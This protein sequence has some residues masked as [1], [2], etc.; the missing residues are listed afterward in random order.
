[1]DCHEKPAALG[2]EPF[3]AL[4]GNPNSGKSVVFHQLTGIYTTVSNYPGTTLQILE[5]RV[6]KKR[7]I[8][9][10]GVYSISSATTEERITLDVARHASC[11]VNIVNAL[12]LD[13]ELFLTLQLIDMGVPL[14]IVLNVTDEA[15]KR[16][17]KID[18]PLLEKR[19]GT[20]IYETVAVTG[21]GIKP[22]ID[23]IKG[24]KLGK[25]AGKQPKKCS[26]I[27][28]I[29]DQFDRVLAREG[30][31]E[32]LQKYGLK[33]G[34]MPDE[35]YQER[36]RRVNAL[37]GE[38]VTKEKG[39]APA[40]EKLSQLMVH[41]VYGFLL[42]FI[43]IFFA[44]QIIGVFVAQTIVGITEGSLM[45]G[46]YVPF[47]TSVI[48]NLHLPEWISTI[49]VGE[50]GVFTMTIAYLFGLLLPLVISFYLLLS[51]LEDSGYLPRLAFLIDRS[52]NRFGLN[53]KAIIPLILGFGCVT[54]ATLTTRMLDTEREKTIASSLLNFTIPCSAQ[55]AVITA[56]IAHAGGYFTVSY[57]LIIFSCFVLIGSVLAR[58]VRGESSSLVISLPVLQRPRVKNMLMK[59]YARTRHFMKEAGVW[60][61]VGALLL[62]VMQLTGVLNWLQNLISFIVMGWL[63][64]PKEAATAYI[65]GIVRR[66][67]GAAGF[68]TMGLTPIQLLV[69]LVT[70]TLFVPCIAA[71]LMLYKERGPK[72]A[73]I[74]WVGSIFFSFF[75]GG[76]IF[77]LWRAAHGL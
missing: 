45:N 54:M 73:T 64:L 65:M 34:S 31:K 70:I 55:L 25:R 27:E 9:S 17:M 24:W 23:A 5:G 11:V 14:I 38:T 68:Y 19:L 62:S 4:I 15:K 13:R 30:G 37:L 18:I 60:F 8:D 66:D 40:D 52:L 49:L 41:P 69:A 63:G 6:G 50:F 32:T 57:I 20:N 26:G 74:L 36:R 51:F 58:M 77:Q 43:I 33:D 39:N 75:I 1:V 42:F 72:I 28:D 35:S 2:D 48:T 29:P 21:E 22:L 71:I 53:G 10:P 56:L 12:H 67:F 44:Y 7:I 3:I 76:V 47:I 16:G 46:Y 61:F 59:S